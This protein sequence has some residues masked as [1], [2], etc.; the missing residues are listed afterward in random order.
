MS[1][2]QASADRLKPSALNPA[3][4]CPLSERRSQ[5]HERS[6]IV[7]NRREF[8]RDRGTKVGSRNARLRSGSAL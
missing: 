2:D 1:E 5:M 6:M 7:A 4:L 3:S 8:R